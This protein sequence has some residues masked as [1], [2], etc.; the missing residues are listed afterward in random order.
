MKKYEIMYIID[1]TVLEE[2]RAALV[3]E[4]KGLFAANGAT[5]LKVE[6]WGERKLAYPIKK[7]KSG[8]YVLTTF[9]MDGTQLTN[10]ENKLNIMEKVIRYRIFKQD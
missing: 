1:P 5:N 7:K 4:V 8:F 9:E 3:E 2:E 10:V 6:N